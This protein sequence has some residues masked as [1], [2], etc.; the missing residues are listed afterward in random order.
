[1]NLLYC[2]VLISIRLKRKIGVTEYLKGSPTYQQLNLI[3]EP[4]CDSFSGNQP[5]NT[6]IL[7]S[8][9]KSNLQTDRTRFPPTSS[10]FF[11]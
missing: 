4:L 8:R 6:V 9:R 10:V 5:V 2:F 1:M 3:P 7:L 11:G